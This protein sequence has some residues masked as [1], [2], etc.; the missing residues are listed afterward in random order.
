MGLTLTRTPHSHPNPDPNPH[1]NPHQVRLWAS[2]RGQTLA[3]TV[4]GMQH[5]E[6]ALKLQAELEAGR[7]AGEAGG[8]AACGAARG[9]ADG[10]HTGTC[11]AVH[12]F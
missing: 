4:V 8:E 2:L 7:E 11:F 9:E 1:R 6:A 5:F 10:L 12:K 3:R